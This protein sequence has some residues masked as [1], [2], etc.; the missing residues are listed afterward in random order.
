MN[1]ELGPENTILANENVGG[2]VMFGKNHIEPGVLVEPAAGAAS[3]SADAFI[4]LIW[5]ASEPRYD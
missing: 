4:D 2:V 1:V 5:C 3:R